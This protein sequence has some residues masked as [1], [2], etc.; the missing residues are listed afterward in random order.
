M[1]TY[2]LSKSLDPYNFCDILAKYL[3]I[4]FDY[5]ITPWSVSKAGHFPKGLFERNSLSLGLL[6][7]V[8]F[9]SWP[10]RA[11]TVRTLFVRK[12]PIWPNKFILGYQDLLFLYLTLFIKMLFIFFI[13]FYNL[14]SNIFETCTKI[15]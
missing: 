14:Q 7:T 4:E 1:T 5:V 13:I 15:Y 11:D 10:L 9:T 8:N 2:P 3:A 6:T 12:F